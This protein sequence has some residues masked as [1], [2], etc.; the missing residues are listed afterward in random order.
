MALNGMTLFKLSGG[1]PKIFKVHH[2]IIVYDIIL[3]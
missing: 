3:V 1:R 2:A